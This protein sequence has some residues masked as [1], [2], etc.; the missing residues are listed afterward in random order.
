MNCP[1]CQKDME[2]GMIQSARQI[3]FSKIRKKFI[4]LADSLEGDIVVAKMDWLFSS[5]SH[6]HHC[7][8]CKKVIVDLA[9]ER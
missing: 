2:S 3:F 5:Y 4:M 6:A 9:A 7:P 8:D 1:F